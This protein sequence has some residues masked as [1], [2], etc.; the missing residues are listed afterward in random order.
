MLWKSVFLKER[1]QCLEFLSAPG[2]HKQ[3]LWCG[4][5]LR[6]LVFIYLFCHCSAFGWQSKGLEWWSRL[7]QTHHPLLCSLP[8]EIIPVYF[9]NGSQKLCCHSCLQFRQSVAELHADSLGPMNTKWRTRRGTLLRSQFCL[10]HF[11]P[12]C[13]IL[14]LRLVRCPRHFSVKTRAHSHCVPDISLR[15]LLL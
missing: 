1:E 6:F 12:R 13:L 7:I 2:A 8:L 11:L 5:A 3:L 4:G 10:L 14:R 9:G 15:A